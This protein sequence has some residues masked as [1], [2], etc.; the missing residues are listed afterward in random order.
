MVNFHLADW[1]MI[2]V[3]FTAENGKYQPSS[4][5][6]SSHF[7]GRL[8]QWEDV[9]TVQGTHPIV[10]VARGSHA[11]YYDPEPLG[12]PTG[13]TINEISWGLP[14]LLRLY[15]KL[16]GAF[17]GTEVSIS[18][19]ILQ[20][21]PEGLSRDYVPLVVYDKAEDQFR[22]LY[23][24]EAAP[25]I[26]PIRD[27]VMHIFPYFIEGDIV[28]YNHN[29]LWDKW[30]WL[31]YQGLWGLGIKGPP[32]QGDRWGDPWQWAKRLGMPDMTAAWKR[33]LR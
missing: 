29:P 3:F 8:R 30:W 13:A 15:A 6:Y 33:M 7:N 16:K 5:A 19:T 2:T 22:H 21:D 20:E 1:E 4:C 12:F 23:D 32:F 17:L 11:N 26:V 9:A 28:P 24:A 10:H 25:P 31:R 27:A 18:T 14:G